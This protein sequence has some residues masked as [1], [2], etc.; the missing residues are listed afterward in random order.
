[1][2]KVLF[3]VL[4]TLLAIP[5][6]SQKENSAKVV[7]DNAYA[8][9]KNAG[10]I[11]AKFSVSSTKGL[12]AIGAQK[13][14]IMLKG[15]KFLLK[16]STNIIWFNGKTQ[17]NYVYK[18][19][20]V[21]V[22]NPSTSELQNINPYYILSIYQKGFDYKLG[23]ASKYKGKAAKEVLLTAQNKKQSISSITIYV[24]SNDNSPLFISITR[25][26]GSRNDLNISGYQTHQN[27]SDGIFEFNKKDYP[28]VEVVDLR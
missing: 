22:T 14:T 17:W 25:R 24:S 4:V 13:G 21:N 1:M 12:K 3:L 28:K 7:L 5:A 8:A 11:K 18:N 23:N 27:F 2:K 6:Y 20:E 26:D 16:S 19:K 10:G 15:T 9:L